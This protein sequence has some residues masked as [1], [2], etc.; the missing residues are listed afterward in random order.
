MLNPPNTSE[1]TVFLLPEMKFSDKFNGPVSSSM[2]EKL[3]GLNSKYPDSFNWSIYD[4]LYEK[5]GNEQPRG[6]VV[7]KTNFKLVNS[8]HTCSKC[9]YSFEIDTYGRGCVHDCIYCYAKDSLIK[10]N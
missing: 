8:H 6:G 3:K 7:F 10:K 5:F 2:M 4:E 9:H 1:S